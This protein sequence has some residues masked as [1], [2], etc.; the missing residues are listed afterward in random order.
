MSDESWGFEEGDEIAPGLTS[1]ELLAGGWANE[2]YVAWSDDLLS[3]VVAKLIRPD[4]IEDESALRHLRRE[5]EVLDS[6]AHPVIMRCFQTV[7]DGPRPHL[8]LEHME[9]P[10]LRELMDYGPLPLE[11]LIPLA[12]TLCSA[13]HYMARRNTVHLDLKPSNIVMSVP[14]RLIDFS[15]AR[16]FEDAEALTTDIGT[17]D[18]MAPEQCNPGE[19][20]TVGPWSDMWALGVTLYEAATGKRPFP[21]GI[22]DHEDLTVRYPQLVHDADLP[23]LDVPEPIVGP[24]MQCLEREPSARPT[25]VQLSEQFEE[26]LTL[27]SRKRVLSRK[28]PKLR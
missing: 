8:V 16:S 14:D 13:L 10:T 24:I 4:Q 7:P 17:A 20:G 18:Y 9:G 11:Q 19:G 27:L 5:A 28:R 2:T 3:I 26:L 15:I 21:E 22:E 1:L 12:G 25:A 23:P 6:L